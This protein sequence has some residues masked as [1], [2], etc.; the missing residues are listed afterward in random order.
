M[1][2]E[3]LGGHRT[4][5]FITERVT[6]WLNLAGV[7]ALAI[8]LWDMLAGRHG[9]GKILRAILV[10]TWA[11]MLAV[12]IELIFMHPV[13]DRLLVRG[14]REIIDEDRF[15]R[16]HRVYL[17]SASGQWCAGVL[18]VAALAIAWTPRSEAKPQ[19]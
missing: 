15:D 16:L 11:T 3:V 13:M 18:H 6:Q 4:V 8:L 12:Q 1:A 10:I 14:A 17:W 7:V 9:R 19:T 2:V 5:G